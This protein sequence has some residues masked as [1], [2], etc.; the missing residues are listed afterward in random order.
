MARE[1]HPYRRGL[2]K[3]KAAVFLLLVAVAV[4]CVLVLIYSLMHA[5]PHADPTIEDQPH[6]SRRAQPDTPLLCAAPGD[7]RAAARG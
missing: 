3:R 1:I 7:A 6:T 5:R 4:L 2:D